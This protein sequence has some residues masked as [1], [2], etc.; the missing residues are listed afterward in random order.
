MNEKY[1]DDHQGWSNEQT[2]LFNIWLG[3]ECF[4]GDI[5]W[6]LENTEEENQLR[7]MAQTLED[8][9]NALLERMETVN[10]NNDQDFIYSQVA[11]S[12]RYINFKE[13]AEHYLDSYIEQ[14]MPCD[15]V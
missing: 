12:G 1:R 2:F 6:I 5:K 13:L 3:M 4:A 14:N 8:S 7:T 15:V 10:G 11:V 9:F